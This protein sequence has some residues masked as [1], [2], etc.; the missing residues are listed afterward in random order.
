MPIKFDTAIS[1]GRLAQVLSYDPDCGEFRWRV[2]LGSKAPAGN[3]AGSIGHYGYRTIRIDRRDYRAARLAWLYVTGRWPT[4]LV[5]HIDGNRSND[6]WANLREATDSENQANSKRRTDQPYHKGV[7][8]H[9]AAGKWSAKIQ[10]KHIGLFETP[11]KAA[12]AY[13]QA[14]IVAYGHFARME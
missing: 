3:I 4:K 13:R 8:F 6:R 11:E 5:D 9:K 2:T 10:G 12:A 14:A 7:S 1:R